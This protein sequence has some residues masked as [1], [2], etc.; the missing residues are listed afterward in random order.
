MIYC[1]SLHVLDL[2]LVNCEICGICTNHR[3]IQHSGSALR[4]CGVSQQTNKQTIPVI[5][6]GNTPTPA[7]VLLFRACLLHSELFYFT[8]DPLVSL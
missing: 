4:S 3:E 1:V 6:D 5:M 8:Q 7:R 2:Q